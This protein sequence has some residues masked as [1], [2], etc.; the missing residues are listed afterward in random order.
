[1][2]RCCWCCFLRTDSLLIAI[3][4]F[5]AS[6][7]DLAKAAVDL[8]PATVGDPTP[9]SQQLHFTQHEHLI[10]IIVAAVF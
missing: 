3:V 2:S 10:S 9:A 7:I 4:V 1:M 8:D 6:G 5:H